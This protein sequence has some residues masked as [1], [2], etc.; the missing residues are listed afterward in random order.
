MQEDP[1]NKSHRID[2]ELIF[3]VQ[4]PGVP[5]SHFN[6]T[7]AGIR[8]MEVY[9]NIY[10]YFFTGNEQLPHSQKLIWS[11]YSDVTGFSPQKR[12][13]IGREMGNPAISG[14]FSGW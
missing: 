3:W 2:F 5:Y 10:E 4:G 1:R 6:G 8:I 11:N 9:V 12:S 7:Y 14:D 13:Q